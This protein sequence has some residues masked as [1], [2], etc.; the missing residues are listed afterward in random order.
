MSLPSGEVRP[1]WADNSEILVLRLYIAAETPNSIRAVANL[2][3]ICR[4]F[5]GDRCKV[6]MV[7]ILKE[8]LRAL[9]E[10]VLVTPTLIKLSPPPVQKIVGDLSEILTVAHALGLEVRDEETQR[11]LGH[12][13]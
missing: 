8:P 2:K 3:I 7:D 13:G 4:E 1:S 11:R 10:G 9:G 6:E 12:Q 5:C